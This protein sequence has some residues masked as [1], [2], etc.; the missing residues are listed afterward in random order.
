MVLVLASVFDK[1]AVA[2]VE[3]FTGAAASVLTCSSLALTP[4]HICY[5]YPD[6]S[7]ITVNKQ[8]L[9]LKDITGIIN[10]LQGIIPEEM[11]FFDETEYS[12]QA[13]EFTALISFLCSIIPGPMVNKPLP[14]SL[15]GLMNA[16]CWQHIA[17][18]LNI[19]QV[20][21]NKQDNLYDSKTKNM[22][23]CYYLNKQI[24]GDNL[25]P[26]VQENT[27]RL[28]MFSGQ[29]FL[30]ANYTLQ[31]DFLFATTLPDIG[32]EK[33]SSILCEHFNAKI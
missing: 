10:L 6:E 30:E 22:I 7:Y 12:Y 25:N 1:A 14:H 27:R 23:T 16:L 26:L 33:V 29:S 17:A 20:V 18:T 28:A 5:P 11:Y 4:T 9:Y 24:F 19:R 32:N 8:R 3:R 15:S 13:Q 2:F 31:S 21:Y